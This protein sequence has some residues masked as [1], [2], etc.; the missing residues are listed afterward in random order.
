MG[1]TP[2]STCY[3]AAL[4]SVLVGSALWVGIATAQSAP[5]VGIV[6]SAGGLTLEDAHVQVLS[7]RLS[8]TTDARGRFRF[9]N[10]PVGPHDITVR[11]LGYSP[12]T[13]R[14]ELTPADSLAR[15]FVLTPIV[16]LEVVRVET[17]RVAI[18]E[19]E[20]RRARGAGHFITRPELD[21]LPHRRMAD[22]LRR[23]PGLR[24]TTNSRNR[25]E[26]YAINSRGAITMSG[27]NPTCYV[28][29]YLDGAAV[30]SGGP[31]PPYNVNSLRTDDVEAVEYYAGG[32]SIPAEF[33]RT[34][35][36]CGV[37]VIW[38]RR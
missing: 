31:Q 23:V 35:S 8:A 7:M 37:L 28:Q 6:R 10:L 3:S 2:S 33:N 26:V 30:F 1:A 29:V 14:V 17:T 32:A 4:R 22:V 25:D 34:G 21:R 11:R 24:L 5:L 20:D 36:A 38:T 9:E 12:I 16:E 19:F 15:S 18:P 27:A 13:V